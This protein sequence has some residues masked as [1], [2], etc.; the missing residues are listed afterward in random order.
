MKTW[1]QIFDETGDWVKTIHAIYQQVTTDK[2]VAIKLLREY[3][4]NHAM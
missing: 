1:K 2:I 4:D 3:A